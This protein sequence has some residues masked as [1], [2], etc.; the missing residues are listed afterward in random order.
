MQIRLKTDDQALVEALREHYAARR[1]VPIYVTPPAL[2]RMALRALAT[3]EGLGAD[4]IQTE[5]DDDPSE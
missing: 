2:V 3:A 4:P 1:P 5:S